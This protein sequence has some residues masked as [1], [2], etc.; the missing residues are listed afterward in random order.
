LL[1]ALAPW[2]RRQDLDLTRR[3]RFCQRHIGLFNTNPYLANLV[4]GGLLR[5]ES[6]DSR[7][8]ST[9]AATSVLAYRDTLARVCGSIGD[10][11]FWLGLRPAWQY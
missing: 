7:E 1:V 11:L 9:P 5:L 4:I 3:R 10:Q 2:L 6:E 8:A